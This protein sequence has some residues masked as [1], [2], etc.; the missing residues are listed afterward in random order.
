MTF[1]F[2]LPRIVFMALIIA[3]EIEIWKKVAGI[4]LE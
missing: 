3:R 1:Q 2:S 4:R